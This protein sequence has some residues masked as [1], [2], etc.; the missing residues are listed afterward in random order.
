VL[1]STWR[2]GRV[3]VFVTETALAFRNAHKQVFEL[4]EYVPLEVRGAC[5]DKVFAFLRS[6][7]SSY[8][9]VVVPRLMAGLSQQPEWGDTQVLLPEA[10]ALVGWKNKLTGERLQVAGGAL[11]VSSILSRFPVAL[12]SCVA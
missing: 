4:G 10:A 5:S 9:V 8:V 3:K 12:L 1:L 7:E 6:H 11:L 2:D